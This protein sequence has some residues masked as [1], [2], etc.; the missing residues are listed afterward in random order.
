MST[1]PYEFSSSILQT[2][3]LTGMTAPEKAG[4]LLAS[5]QLESTLSVIH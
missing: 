4:G 1:A 3:P 2:I 5:K